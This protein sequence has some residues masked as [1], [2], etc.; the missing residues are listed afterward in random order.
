MSTRISSVRVVS[1]THHGQGTKFF[2]PLPEHLLP[3]LRHI[4]E[5]E[6]GKPRSPSLAE[7]SDLPVIGKVNN[8]RHLVRACA[9]GMVYA[10][11]RP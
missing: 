8:G 6:L 1:Y 7:M 9:D 3:S 5:E 10:L 4:E 11:G 2:G